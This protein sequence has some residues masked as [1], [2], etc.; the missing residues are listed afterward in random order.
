MNQTISAT[1]NK[2][3]P[4]TEKYRPS[5]I[6]QILSQNIIVSTLKKLI[7]NGTFLHLLFH[8]PPGSGKTSTILCCAYALYGPYV[9]HMTLMLN[10]SYDRGIETVRKKIK[11]FI[12]CQTNVFVPQKYRSLPK[13]VILDETD[14]MTVDAQTVL[15]HLFEKYSVSSR[16]CMLCNHRDKISEPLQSRCATFRFSPLSENDMAIKMTE[17]SQLEN[18]DYELGVLESIIK[19]SKGDMRIAINTLQHVSL[20][21]YG[22]KIL[23]KNVYMVSGHCMPEINDHI[24][25][26]L[27]HIYSEHI[28]IEN[29]VNII[30]DIIIDNN[31]AIFN[32]LEELKN[33]V[34]E[35]QLSLCQKIYLIGNFSDCEVYDSY[36][37]DV[38]NI[39]AVICGIFYCVRNQ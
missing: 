14:S 27:M 15:R 23:I 30:H 32:L 17:I 3:M 13:L 22:E 7:E 36:S 37:I 16:F 31:V 10:A 19:I 2:E 24:F 1:T 39:V 8:G 12:I 26:T 4:W 34:L 9:E 35:S 25:Q 20:S 38:F 21:C 28:T 6:D 29:G 5:N 18:L 33:F 11:N